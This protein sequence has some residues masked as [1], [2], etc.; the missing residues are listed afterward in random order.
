MLPLAIAITGWSGAG[1]TTVIE[2][3]LPGLAARGLS[4]GVL[5]HDAHGLDLDRP[6][7]DT[8]RFRE[9]GAARVE[10]FDES[11]W[12][13]V[14]PTPPGS[15]LERLPWGWRQDVDLIIVE[16]G[17]GSD[18]DKIWIEGPDA[19]GPPA[20]VSRVIARVQR[21]GG[22]AGRVEEIIVGWL[23]ARWSERRK[24]VVVLAGGASRRMGRPKQSIE[25]E[26]GPLLGRV[27]A[28]ARGFTAEVVVAGRLPEGVDPPDGVATLPDVPGIHG[29]LGGMLAAMR[30]GPSMSWCVLPCDHPRMHT[31]FLD[32][33]WSLRRPSIWAVLPVDGTGRPNALAAVYEPQAVHLLEEAASHGE[34][35][36]LRILEA[37]PSV[38]LAEPPS[39]LVEALVD[40]DTPEELAELDGS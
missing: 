37:H 28:E 18:I 13:Q 24:A 10:A 2:S 12:F 11:W 29:P 40:V 21:D 23:E 19:K 35:S 4:V 34:R 20:D 8:H 22:A 27:V 26:A 25:V 31:R 3:L 39:D 6:G 30:W 16:G 38:L 32:W 7:K 5:K 33:L 17:K 1:K 15:G 36:A 9:A 14:A